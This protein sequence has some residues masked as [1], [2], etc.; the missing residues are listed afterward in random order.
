MT[1]SVPAQVRFAINLSEDLRSN[2]PSLLQGAV[3]LRQAKKYSAYVHK[4]FSIISL[5]FTRVFS[6]GTTF[7]KKHPFHE[8]MHEL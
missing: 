1:L 8:T 7:V 6:S 3:Y 2:W 4:S 5:H